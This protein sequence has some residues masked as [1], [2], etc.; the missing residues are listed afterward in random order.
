MRLFL[1]TALFLLS[2]SAGAQS[3]AP[4]DLEGAWDYTHY[5]D[6]DTPDQKRPVGAKMEF[7]PDGT[8]VM[9]LSTGRADA[10]W[11]VEGNTIVYNDTNGE[12]VWQVR[13]YEPGKSLVVEHRRA[14]MFFERAE[15]E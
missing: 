1:L 4:Q 13:S 8:L 9:T 6:A 11:A 7:R 5:A 15:A 14:L 12:Q 3:L 10:T 2:T